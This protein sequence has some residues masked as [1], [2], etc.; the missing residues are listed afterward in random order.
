MY[1]LKHLSAESLPAAL[2]RAKHFRLLN[3]PSQAESICL[4]VL[5]KDPENQEALVTLLLAV[6]D[7]FGRHLGDRVREAKALIP[8]L[9]SE[10][11]RLYYTG[12][13]IE[14]QARAELKRGAPGHGSAVYD[15]LREAMRWYE[16]AEQLHP[17]GQ[18]ETI[19]R[20]NACAR[21]INKHE[22]VQ[23]GHEDDFVPLLE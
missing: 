4:D 1:E 14:R 2:E 17:Q 21:T 15:G 18:E 11:Q 13:I 3:E 6:T 9:G 10:Y 7:Q 8:R 19:L 22:H 20:W 23:P 12:I 16:K 5:D